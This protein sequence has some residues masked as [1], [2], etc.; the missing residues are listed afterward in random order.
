MGDFE[1]IEPPPL[2]KGHLSFEDFSKPFDLQRLNQALKDEGVVDD[3]FFPKRVEYLRSI[4][5]IP[6]YKRNPFKA[7]KQ[8]THLFLALLASAS[9]TSPEATMVLNLNSKESNVNSVGFEEPQLRRRENNKFCFEKNKKAAVEKSLLM[10][11]EKNPAV[12]TF[13][14]GKSPQPASSPLFGDPLSS[15]PMNKK[16]KAEIISAAMVSFQL[17][18]SKRNQRLLPS[19]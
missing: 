11:K 16:L 17:L 8:G 13:T 12:L 1:Q 19:F 2:T 6:L 9:I 15:N 3:S 10:K 14:A 18:F 4:Q 5:K 7:L